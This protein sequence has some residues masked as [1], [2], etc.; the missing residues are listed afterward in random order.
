[1]LKPAAIIQDSETADFNTERCN[2]TYSASTSSH[3]RETCT[4]LLGVEASSSSTIQQGLF[5]LPCPIQSQPSRPPC[6]KTSQSALSATTFCQPGASFAT[7]AFLGGPSLASSAPDPSN[8]NQTVIG[9]ETGLSDPTKEIFK[10]RSPFKR[11][12]VVKGVQ[13]SAASPTGARQL[14]TN[15]AAQAESREVVISAGSMDQGVG[16]P[17]RALPPLPPRK[18]TKALRKTAQHIMNVSRA[19]QVLEYDCHKSS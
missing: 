14:A 6:R 19:F 13:G 18:K 4:G 2:S 7:T 15:A 5:H 8:T 1:M 11:R 3:S 10:P 16:K 17:A 12:T 9:P